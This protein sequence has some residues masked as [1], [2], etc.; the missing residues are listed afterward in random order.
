MK[1]LNQNIGIGHAVKLLGIKEIGT[2]PTPDGGEVHMFY[3]GKK[4]IVD[5]YDAYGESHGRY[6]YD[7]YD[8]ARLETAGAYY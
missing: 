1:N 8:E 4:V 3:Q 5:H 6:A 2:F 7:S